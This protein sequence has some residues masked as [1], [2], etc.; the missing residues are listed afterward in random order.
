MKYQTLDANETRSFLDNIDTQPLGAKLVIA[1]PLTLTAMTPSKHQRF[2]LDG[3]SWIDPEHV[4][5]LIS[6]GLAHIERTVTEPW[7]AEAV[8]RGWLYDTNDTVVCFTKKGEVA[9]IVPN[10][11]DPEQGFCMTLNGV[12][13]RIC[14]ALHPLLNQVTPYHMEVAP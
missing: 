8:R 11:V 1:G 9:R 6:R 12:H 7:Y 4:E 5:S 10:T 14:K 13:P 2:A 3:G